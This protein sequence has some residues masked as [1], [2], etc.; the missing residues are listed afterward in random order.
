MDDTLKFRKPRGTFLRP[1]TER[2]AVDLRPYDPTD[3]RY[4]G[5][6]RCFLCGRKLTPTT[7]T[8]EHVFP[9]WLLNRYRLWDGQLTLLNGSSI[10]YRK[11]KIPSCKTCNGVYLGALERR[12][13]DAVRGGYEAFRRLPRAVLFQWLTKI[14]FQILYLEMRLAMDIRNPNSGTILTPELLD[15]F[16]LEHA[17]LNSVR[18]P[19]RVTSPPPWSIFVV[20]A[21]VSR[22]RERNFDFLDNLHGQVVAIR[23]GE[24]AVISALMDGH[25][26]EAMFRSYFAKLARHLRLHPLQFRELAAM[27]IY[28]RRTMNRTPKFMTVWPKD[29]KSFE[30]VSLPLAGFS[31]RPIF[32]DWQQEEY[33]RI[34]HFIAGVPYGLAYD[35][36]FS[37]PDKVMT[38][39]RNNRNRYTRIP[40]DSEPVGASSQRSS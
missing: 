35:E 32:G 28:K 22:V 14:F 17:L 8:S 29:Q 21:Q 26:Q 10:S 27:A 11:V 13:E 38:F 7:R 15:E 39:L 19:V 37:P 40:I 24:V 16:R 34:L 1:H 4:L 9:K 20:P 6:D 18:V 2:G 30:V 3:R 25:A 33:A 5:R 31:L 36:L 12:I 23:M